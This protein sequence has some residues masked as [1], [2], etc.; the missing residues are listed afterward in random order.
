MSSHTKLSTSPPLE[1]PDDWPAEAIPFSW[2]KALFDQMKFTYG[3]K[4]LDQWAGISISGAMRHWAMKL[5][6]LSRAELTVGWS[7]LETL[8]W[9]PTLPEFIKLCRPGID[10]V[11]AFY[12]ALEQGGRRERGEPDEWSSPAIYWAWRKIGA[13]D[14]AHSAYAV[15]RSRWEAALA[16]EMDKDQ[17]DPIP[18]QM[19]ALPAPGKTALATERAQ[20]LLADFKVKGMGGSVAAGDGRNWARKIL[21]RKARGE[22]MAIALWES[23]EQAL[24]MR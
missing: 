14:F 2:V 16:A 18:P 23:A 24:G 1:I 12:E 13:F 21:E 15:L 17:P 3:V 8:A 4:F 7:T 10:P 5:K 9:P 19:V 22:P 20:Q 6:P 11:V